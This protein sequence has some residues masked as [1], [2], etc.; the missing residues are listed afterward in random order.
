MSDLAENKQSHSVINA[1]ISEATIY[2]YEG[3]S[4]CHKK[5]ENQ[6]C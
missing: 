3:C 4:N 6:N 5:M 1:K 2:D